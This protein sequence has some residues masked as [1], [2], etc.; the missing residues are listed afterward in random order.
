MI[1]IIYKAV[2]LSH[3]EKLQI[4]QNVNKL[5]VPIHFD[6]FRSNFDRENHSSLHPF[7]QET[8]FSRNSTWSFE[9]GTGAW[10]KM[11]RFNAFSR[12]VNIINW[13][14]FP[15]NVKI[16][17]SE[18][19]QQAFLRDNLKKLK[20]IWNDIFLRLILED[21]GVKKTLFTNFLV[22]T[23]GFRYFRK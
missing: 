16:Y 14:F 2:R 6:I 3:L 4:I 13:K 23:C 9:W 10:V 11:R 18:K 21:K 19:I 17:K 1:D 7:C 5:N 8:R 20:D 15:T 12:N 22:I